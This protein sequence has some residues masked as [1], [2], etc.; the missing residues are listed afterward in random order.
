MK[1]NKRIIFATIAALSL[2]APMTAVFNFDNVQTVSAN[3][4]GTK[5]WLQYGTLKYALKGPS[6][7]VYPAG[8]KVVRELSDD[9]KPPISMHGRPFYLTLVIGGIPGNQLLQDVGGGE[10]AE[11][12]VNYE[13]WQEI[14]YPADN[15][16]LVQNTSDYT[17]LKSSDFHPVDNSNPDVPVANTDA[18]DHAY[19]Q[20]VK[21]TYNWEHM[22]VADNKWGDSINQRYDAAHGMGA[23]QESV[24]ALTK[25]INDAVANYKKTGHLVS[26]NSN[27]GNSSNS[28]NSNSGS[29]TVT[30]AKR[31]SKSRFVKL[32]KAS[33]Q[34]TH[35]GKRVSKKK[36][37]KGAIVKI[38]GKTYR[39]K[40]KTF[41]HI[42]KNRYIRKVN[43]A[44]N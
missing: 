36:L 43:V 22:S 26:G 21:N 5:V 4:Q 1:K 11:A 39:I 20:Y 15:V 6:G 24:D 16:V 30:P 40:K 9:A 42:G 19:G 8:T 44:K 37:K 14:D 35:K 33:Y 23:T 3:H 27:S 12:Y 13:D 28:S 10:I 25:E 41:Y 2:A 31:K 34:Y 29:T 17:D 18:L 38:N 32:R 7:R